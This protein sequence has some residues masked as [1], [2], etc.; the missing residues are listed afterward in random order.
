MLVRMVHCVPFGM[1]PCFTT[2]FELRSRHLEARR[3]ASGGPTELV[4][5]A[6]KKGQSLWLIP[7]GPMR[8]P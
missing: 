6:S 8:S 4:S 1:H 3:A 2:L 5:G 7:M